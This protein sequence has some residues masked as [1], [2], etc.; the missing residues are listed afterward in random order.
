M[1][2][3]GYALL[4]AVWSLGIAGI[5][6]SATLAFFSAISRHTLSIS[7]SNQATIAT[8][9][10]HAAIGT[11]LRASERNRLPF[12]T[13]R[14]PGGS[15]VLPHGGE[16]PLSSLTGPTSPAS[17]SD[18]VSVIDLAHRHHG[19]V[20]TSNIAGTS[21]EAEICHLFSPIRAN[22]FKSFILYTLDGARQVVGD[23][24]YRSASCITLTGTSIRGLVSF[25]TQFLSHPISFVPVEREYSLFID[26]ASNFRISSHIGA[27][28]MENQPVVRGIKSISLERGEHSPGAQT[29]TLSIQPTFGARVQR[30]FIP[31]LSQRMLWNEMLP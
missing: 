23:I 9:K 30:F 20:A 2:E 1:K 29:F 12:S 4:D 13:V 5:I 16:H 6:L 18:I 26:R 25:H 27:R 10:V 11:A 24:T 3:R 28:I 15:L 31:G 14:T 8:M 17:N 21:V 7:A 19:R 22:E